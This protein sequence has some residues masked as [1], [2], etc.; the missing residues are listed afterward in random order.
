[1]HLTLSAGTD[2]TLVIWNSNTETNMEQA[3]AKCRAR[4]DAVP[5][6]LRASD[7]CLRQLHLRDELEQKKTSRLRGIWIEA[8]GNAGEGRCLALAMNWLVNLCWGE[9]GTLSVERLAET[10][11]HGVAEAKSS[12]L[13][14][15]LTADMD[16][17][18]D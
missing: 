5:A 14:A 1:M 18:Q 10:S 13:E 12:F 4:Q 2:K 3:E 11:F 16:L 8:G 7:V 17:F 6:T 9:F 15:Q